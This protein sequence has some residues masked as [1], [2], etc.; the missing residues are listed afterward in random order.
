MSSSSRSN[1]RWSRSRGAGDDRCSTWLS[2]GPRDPAGFEPATTPLTAVTVSLR[3]A[4][5]KSFVCFEA[6]FLSQ[7][8]GRGIGRAAHAGSWLYDNPGL[9]G[10]T[11]DLLALVSRRARA[12]AASAAV[13]YEACVLR[14]SGKHRADVGQRTSWALRP[15]G[16]PD[17]SPRLPA[18]EMNVRQRPALSRPLLRFWDRA[19]SAHGRASGATNRSC[20]FMPCSVPERTKWNDAGV[21]KRLSAFQFK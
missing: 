7:Q 15:S 3:P 4:R 13:A 18:P 12:A 11:A 1:K 9:L 17:R 19:G 2:Y 14:L 21:T 8:C 20:S 6:N 16:A 5:P 10:R